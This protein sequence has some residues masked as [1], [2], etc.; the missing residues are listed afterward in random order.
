[1]KKM[2][3]F[4]EYQAD[5]EKKEQIAK[6][7]KELEQRKA[8]EKQ[9]A[10]TKKKEEYIKYE[11][12]QNQLDAKLNII[13]QNDKSL[14][15]KPQLASFAKGFFVSSILGFLAGSVFFLLNDGRDSTDYPYGHEPG[16]TPHE[17][18]GNMTYGQAIKNAYLLDDWRHGKGGIFQGMCGMFFVALSIIV[19]AGMAEET[20]SDN[21]KKTAKAKKI[22]KE[23]E[24]LKDYGIDVSE[25]IKDLTPSIK[26]M[27]V[28]LSAI[29]RGYFD[30][31][32][33]GGLDKANYETCVAIVEG[34]LNSHPKEYNK[35]IE[36]I[37]EATLPAEIIKKYG[38]GKTISF[39]ATQKLQ[40]ER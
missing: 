38:K 26:K 22:L 33:T 32:A 10:E 29:D 20:G 27:L 5:L 24:Q 6:E 35:V 13:S 4:D 39:A 18:Y 31:L 16:F 15:Q 30:N 37:D 2:P 8:K 9:E 14:M 36:I 11:I 28:S 40:T 7:Q 12:A 21:E 3:G 1:M 25:L 23:L 34:Y 17:I 19:G